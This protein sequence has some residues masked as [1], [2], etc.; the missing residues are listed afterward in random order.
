MQ[1]FT[2]VSYEM[3]NMPRLCL[4]LTRQV[5]QNVTFGSRTVGIIMCDSNIDYRA[6]IKELSAT[7][8]FD[9]VGGTALG[10]IKRNEEEDISASFM[11]I[12]GD[13]ELITS[14]ALSPPI[15]LENKAEAIHQTYDE[16]A[17]KLGQP[18]ALIITM[19][20]F[21]PALTMED[22]V[23]GLEMRA[24][25]VPIYGAVASSDYETNLSGTFVNGQCYTDRVL[26]QL[27]GGG[28]QPLFA[29]ETVPI[30]PY[31]KTGRVTRAEGNLIHQVD[32]LPFVDFMR[33]HGLKVKSSGEIENPI[34]IYSSSPVIIKNSSTQQT[35]RLAAIC[36]LHYDTGSAVLGAKVAE[37]DEVAIHILR[38]ADVLAAAKT[39][40]NRLMAKIEVAEAQSPYRYS[41][42][43]CTSCGG[44]FMV[45]LGDTSLEGDYTKTHPVARPL[46]ICGFYA[47]G[48]IC[49]VE[50][51]GRLVN[52]AHNFSMTLMAL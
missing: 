24:G 18:P 39:C 19:M 34:A 44:R 15:T 46:A 4:D 43:F 36:D 1:T 12:T 31:L 47:M 22:V 45:L 6:V 38:K 21:L 50:E 20:P 7:Y 37:G 11:I 9:I 42:M 29:A 27:L 49:P 28:I 48:E 25:Q 35:Y 5:A 32:G 14:F 13:E 52:M 30:D 26:V 33:K 10:F 40:V 3:S 51:E 23:T 16:A 41:T 17:A 8:P 2:A